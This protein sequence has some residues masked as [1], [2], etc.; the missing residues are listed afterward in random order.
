LGTMCEEI[1]LGAETLEDA[2]ASA[3]AEIESLLE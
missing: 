2:L 1:L 3:V